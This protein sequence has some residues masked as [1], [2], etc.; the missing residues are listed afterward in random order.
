MASTVDAERVREFNEENTPKFNKQLDKLTR[1]VKASK[2]TVFFTGAGVSTSA[3]VG[4]YRGPSGAWTKR[5]IKELEAKGKART[6]E[7]EA[8]L[9]QLK[10]EAAREEKK[11][12]VKVSMNDAQPT[13]THM[14]MAT[15][16]RL[17]ICHYVVTTNLDGIFRKAGLKGHEQLC[18]LH[19]DIYIERCTACGYDFERNYHVRQDETH[20]HDH[21]VGTC[22]RCG[23]APPAHYKGTPGNLKMKGSKWGGRM[24]G[25]RDKNCGTKDTHINFGERLDEIDWNEADTHCGKADLCIIAG[26]SMSLRHI[27]HFPFM[28]KKV[29][30]INL[31]ATPDD[32][33]A[34][35][36][37]WA[38]CD[39]VFE[40][41]M[42][43]L[44]VEVDPIPVWRPRDSVPIDQIPKWVH[45]YYVK[46]AQLLEE[47]ALLREAEAEDRRKEAEA[48]MMK[49]LSLKD[50]NSD[51]DDENENKTTSEGGKEKTKK[52]A[53]NKKHSEKKKSKGKKKAKEEEDEEVKTIPI[54]KKIEV[55][56]THQLADSSDG[57]VHQWT[58]FVRLP[59]GEED[60]RESL[61]ELIDFVEY[62]LHPTFKPSSVRVDK[63]PFE[64]SR[65]GWG[66][67][68]VGVKVH[69][70]KSTT[71]R[72][73][74]SC[75]TH[76][77]NFGQTVIS[78]IVDA[79]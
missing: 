34:D 31:Q 47:M 36:R 77:L 61:D 76:H 37:I 74:P 6:A 7:E 50:E 72:V 54:P 41:L 78:S 62:E 44:A 56:N 14:A 40:G 32:D 8:E 69:W 4:D 20:V 13:Y 49:N 75:F 59:Q 52:K 46:K 22:E 53:N 35:L 33:K 30:L 3:G 64:L 16:I 17:G 1:M 43:R 12:K 79:N 27:T 73:A 63:A 19:G 23:S 51:N 65:T 71:G 2:Y 10:L 26:T 45:P 29:V 48:K 24:I 15:L 58:M 68:N 11:A 57:N 5:K 9:K 60:N 55:G 39:P 28:A 66:T 21:K 25:T 67:F 42:E 38:K 18:C 70:K